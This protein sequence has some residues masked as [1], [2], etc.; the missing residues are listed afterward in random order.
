MLTSSLWF[1]SIWFL[2]WNAGEWTLQEQTVKKQTGQHRQKRRTIHQ[3][4]FRFCD[5]EENSHIN[6][7]TGPVVQTEQHWQKRTVDFKG[8]RTLL[9]QAEVMKL[10]FQLC[11]LL[12]AWWQ[13]YKLYILHIACPWF[14]AHYLL[15]Y[16]ALYCKEY[17]GEY[18]LIKL[19]PFIPLQCRN[20]A[21]KHTHQKCTAAK[22]TDICKA[23]NWHLQ[24]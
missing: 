24:D 19:M 18:C 23:R 14:C 21:A 13:V 8:H 9:A 22:T 3:I 10:S 2:F 5:S 17:N 11:F 7:C 6:H 1:Q 16:T 12:C 4:K 20:K 15:H